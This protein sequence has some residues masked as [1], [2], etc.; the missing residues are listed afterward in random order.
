MLNYIWLALLLLA[1]VVGGLTG[2]SREVTEAAL[3]AAKTSVLT[4]AL[5]LIGITALWLG[6]MRLAERAG[7]IQILARGL[8]PLLSRLFPEVPADHPAMGS[9]LL[10]MAANMIGLTNAA[11]PLGLR[12][13]KDLE[14]LNPRP[15]TATNAMC[16]FLAVNTSSIQLVPT[17]AIGLMAAAG[18]ANPVAIVGTSLLATAGST[19]VAIAAVKTLER[20]RRFRLPP[21]PPQ[22]PPATPAEP[23]PD[24]LPPATTPSRTSRAAT[25]A[26]LLLVAL[27][28]GLWIRALTQTTATPQ[29]DPWAV[30][31][32]NELSVLAIPFMLAFFPLYAALRGVPVYEEFVQGA[33]EGFE[34]VVRII[35]YLVAMLV[36]VGTFRAAGCIDWLSRLLQ[37]ALDL[38][39]FPAELLPMALTRPLSGSATIGLFADLVNTLGPDHLVSRMGGTILGSTE[40]TFYVIAVYF[41]AVGVRRTRHAVAA[42][43][44]ADAA[45]IAASVLVCRMMFG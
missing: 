16:T 2:R 30:R 27:F 45:G 23:P 26:A 18:S 13:M 41:G 11:T 10:N 15:G 3:D 6:L 20:C 32:L 17:T 5:P 42:G 35:P 25:I 38:A 29:A 39:R 44:L 19:L 9:M 36:A 28:V 43:L 1:V 4:I 34:V 33:K 14:S 7:L 8:R 24:A 12:A 21:A 40:T 31:A 37:P 22:P